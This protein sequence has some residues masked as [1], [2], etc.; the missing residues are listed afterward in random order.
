VSSGIASATERLGELTSGIAGDGGPGRPRRWRPVGG[1]PAGS[2]HPADRSTAADDWYGG[3][4]PS[5][6]ELLDP[7]LQRGVD[8]GGR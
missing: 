1:S 7:A 6:L 4:P 5:P 3:L 8:F 2:A